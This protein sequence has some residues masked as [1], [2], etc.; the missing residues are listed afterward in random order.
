MLIVQNGVLKMFIIQ[1]EVVLL[2]CNVEGKFMR[3]PSICLV[4]PALA[5]TNSGNW[6]TARRWARMLASHYAVRLVPKWDGS[7][8]DLMI[9]LHARRSADSINAWSHQTP[10]RPLMLV[11]T[12]T[13]LYRDIQHDANAQRSLEQAQCLVVLQELGCAVLPVQHRNKCVVCFQS[14]PVRQAQPKTRRHMRLL[15]V[16]HLREEKSPQT[17]FDVALA[18]RGRKDFYFDHI[19]APLDAALGT[20]AAA[21]AQTCPH[22]RWLGGLTHAATRARIARAHILVHPSRIEGGAHVILEAV[23]SGTPVLASRIDGNV[24]MLGADY[25]GYFAPG[26]GAAL[27]RL[28]ERCRDTPDFLAHLSQQCAQRAALFDPRHERATLLRIVSTLLEKKS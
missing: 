11:L 22:Y 20:Q 7:P 16:G 28:I 9:A 24:G 10:Q 1:C 17:Y 4:T 13:D 5:A 15:M 18:L 2:E 19:G 6:Q 27:A 8:A 23:L 21:L 14:A 25:D 26:D 3:T 12:G